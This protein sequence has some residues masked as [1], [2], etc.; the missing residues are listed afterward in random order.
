M[1]RKLLKYDLKWI[2]NKVTIIYF[3]VMFVLAI[4]TAIVEKIQSPITML[5]IIDKI[6]STLMIS[7]A[8]SI[9]ITVLMRIWA[10]FKISIYNDASYLTHTLPVSKN[11]IYNSKILAGIIVILEAF[12]VIAAAFLIVILAVSGTDFIKDLYK[13]ISDIFGNAMTY[14]LI[15][16]TIL[17]VY[18]EVLFM[19]F[20][21]ILGM[22]LAHRSNSN[23]TLKTIIYG[24]IIYTVLAVLVFVFLYVLSLSNTDLKQ[25]YTVGALPEPEAFKEL[26]FYAVLLYIVFDLVLYFLAKKIFNKGV[27]VD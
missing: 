26:L 12:I 4:I 27:N 22:I 7:C 20:S 6:L 19:T 24:I 10:R 21:G 1:L 18:L 15:I 23:K 25:L 2:N 13:S 17:L 11:Q 5:V 14:L 9:A 8:V 16:S 3:I